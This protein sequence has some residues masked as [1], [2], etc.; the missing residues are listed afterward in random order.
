[1][2]LSGVAKE[3]LARAILAAPAILILD[4]A[5]S[6]SD[7][8]TEARIQHARLRLMRGRTGFVI[9]HRLSTIRHADQVLVLDQGRIVERGTHD[10]LMQQRGLY[11]NLYMSQ[12]RRQA[13][14]TT[15]G[16]QWELAGAT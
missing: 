6:S 16:A 3:A 11:Y 4:E 2:R 1:M 7:R 5:T 15:T 13:P 12:F 9:A 8:R 14:Q 10:S